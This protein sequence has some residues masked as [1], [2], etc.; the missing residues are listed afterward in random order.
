MAEQTVDT[1]STT[2]TVGADSGGS[3]SGQ[4]SAG[5][6]KGASPVSTAPSVGASKSTAGTSKGFPAKTASSSKTPHTTS[7]NQP[8]SPAP[9]ADAGKATVQ[10]KVT[11]APT[12]DAPKADAPVAD[13]VDWQKRHADTVSYAA[14]Q[15]NQFKGQLQSQAQ[16]LEKL[17]AFQQEQA[18]KAESLK[19][20]PWNKGHPENDSFNRIRHR[21]EAINEQISRIPQGLTPEDYES[22]KANIMSA[23]GPEEQRMYNDSVADARQF[24]QNFV[25]DPRG[26]L[27]PLVAPMLTEAFQQFQAFM[28]QQQTAVQVQREVKRD[29]ED[30]KLKPLIARHADWWAQKLQSGMPY[31]AAKEMLLMKGELESLQSRTGASDIAAA[32]AAEQDRLAKGRA[33]TT[34][35]PVSKSPSKDALPLAKKLAEADGKKTWGDHMFRY[36]RIAQRQIDNAQA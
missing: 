36:I 13:T 22:R 4:N 7:Q 33:S 10:P 21:A 24:H 20:K 14:K 12:A 26:T 3:A 6:N 30:D 17:R 31:E 32:A 1:G 19:L 2:T 15:A 28:Q 8:T 9:T 27:A 34:R 25:S 35:D 18:Q 29:F 16:E 11:S 23:L 5:A